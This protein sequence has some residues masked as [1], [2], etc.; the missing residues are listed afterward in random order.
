MKSICIDTEV[1]V[2]VCVCVHAGFWIGVNINIRARVFVACT[3]ARF[4]FVHWE[5]TLAQRRKTEHFVETF[6]S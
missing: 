5:A 4:D 6:R 2:C 3:F 1:C